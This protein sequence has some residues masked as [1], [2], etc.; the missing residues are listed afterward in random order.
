MSSLVVYNYHCKGKGETNA[1]KA[2]D[3][4][5]FYSW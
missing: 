5:H 3:N 1:E 4:I 2:F